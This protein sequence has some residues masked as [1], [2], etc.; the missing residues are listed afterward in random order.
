[1]EW[2]YLVIIV[3]H[4]VKEGALGLVHVILSGGTMGHWSKCTTYE[5]PITQMPT[6]LYVNDRTAPS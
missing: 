5:P 2:L 6:E 1:M 4:T 3:P